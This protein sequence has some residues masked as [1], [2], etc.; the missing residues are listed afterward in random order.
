MKPSVYI[1]TTVISYY[2]ARPSRDLIAAAHQQTT[3]EWWEKA[4]PK[5][6]AYISPFVIGEA[7]RGDIEASAR[8]QNAISN[9]EIL[10]IN[11]EISNLANLYFQKTKLPEKARLDALHLATAVFHGMDY[12]VSWNFTH[13]LNP[14]VRRIVTEINSDR[15]IETPVI[16]TPE[17][18]MEG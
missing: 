9:F 12:I 7:E 10:I 6:D 8:R 3:I 1:E 13:L 18:L 5:F 4:L 15:G 2:S 11:D 16:C 14:I 17:E